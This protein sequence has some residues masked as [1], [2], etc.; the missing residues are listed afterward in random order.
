MNHSDMTSEIVLPTE[1]STAPAAPDLSSDRRDVSHA[2]ENVVTRTA[3]RQ[4][5][6]ELRDRG[7]VSLYNFHLPELLKLIETNNGF[8]VCRFQLFNRPIVLSREDLKDLGG[9]LTIKLPKGPRPTLE[10]TLEN[11]NGEEIIFLPEDLG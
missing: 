1:E 7:E 6:Q 5:L 2:V 11:M 8:P 9:K 3:R 4:K 10:I